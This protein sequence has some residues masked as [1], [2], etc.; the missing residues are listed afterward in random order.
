MDFLGNLGSGLAN[1]FTTSS[2]NTGNSV[3]TSLDNNV[4]GSS[5]DLYNTL[6]GSSDGAGI[7]A[8]DYSKMSELYPTGDTTSSGID[9]SKVGNTVSGLMNAYSTWQNIQ[10]NELLQDSLAYDLAA[11]KEANETHYANAA[12]FNNRYNT[13]A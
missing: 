8:L 12:S 9:L 3:G 5:T 10:T 13:T 1:Y 4:I 11:A 7:G 6:Y 2:S